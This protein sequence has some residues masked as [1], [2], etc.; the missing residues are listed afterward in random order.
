MKLFIITAFAALTFIPVSE[1]ACVNGQEYVKGY[2]KKN[3]T[4]VNGYYRSC[5]D[6]TK[7]N[8]FGKADYP[9]QHPVHRDADKD[10]VPNFAD[11][12]DDND[13]ISDNYDTSNSNHRRYRNDPVII[14]QDHSSESAL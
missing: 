2:T 5:A 1:A 3:G 4:Q 11:R 12:D 10:G 8:N 9:G 6:S 14:I 7:D 13:G